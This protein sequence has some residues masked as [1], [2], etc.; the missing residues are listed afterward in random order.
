MTSERWAP[1]G[2]VTIRSV[3]QQRAT[4]CRPWDFYRVAPRLARRP[5]LLASAVSDELEAT[6][7]L[8]RTVF[9]VRR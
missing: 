7:M 9:V 6:S 4:R 8:V 3:L 1:V 2:V 5:D